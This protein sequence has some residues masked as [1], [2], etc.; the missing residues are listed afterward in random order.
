MVV[1]SFKICKAVYYSFGLIIN[2]LQNK[3][4]KDTTKERAQAIGNIIIY[5][6]SFYIN[7]LCI[8]YE[9]TYEKYF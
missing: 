8:I 6:K 7:L 1:L 3:I 2:F 9:Y 4:N 5:Y